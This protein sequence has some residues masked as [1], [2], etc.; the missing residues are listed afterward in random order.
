MGRSGKKSK[1]Y[2][3]SGGQ[4]SNLQKPTGC[5]TNCPT[6]DRAVL[7]RLKACV[8][9]FR[10]PRKYRRSNRSRKTGGCKSNPARL[11]VSAPAAVVA[12]D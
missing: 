7:R 11:P 5:L 10:H 4:G 12:T 6:K 3:P 8:Y 2:F 1:T 9:Q